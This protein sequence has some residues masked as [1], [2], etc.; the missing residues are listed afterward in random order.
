ML[1]LPTHD[2]RMQSKSGQKRRGT[3]VQVVYEPLMQTGGAIATELHCATQAVLSAPEANGATANE[4]AVQRQQRCCMQMAQMQLP[5]RAAD[6]EAGWDVWASCKQELQKL[7]H[8]TVQHQQCC[9]CT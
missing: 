9:N 1:R 5:P 8:C 7:Q 2:P 6:E 3:N 4:A